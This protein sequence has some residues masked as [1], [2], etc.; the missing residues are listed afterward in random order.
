FLQYTAPL[1]VMRAGPWLLDEPV[2][3]RDIAFFA[4]VAAS[5][6]LFFVDVPLHMETAPRPVAGNAL[7]LL[8]G[9]FWAATTV[10]LR[11]MARPGHGGAPVATAVACGN[12]IAFLACLPLARPVP[13][14]SA[15]DPAI[16][17]YP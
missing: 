7:A 15:R 11:W 12:L 13:Q 14:T 16:G 9:V 10:G 3:R 4:V 6:T 5:L 17:L 2:R 8:S 1:S